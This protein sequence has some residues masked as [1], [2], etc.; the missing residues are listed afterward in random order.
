MNLHFF[1][2]KKKETNKNIGLNDLKLL[3]KSAIME[4]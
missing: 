1:I 2:K 4:I 3:L